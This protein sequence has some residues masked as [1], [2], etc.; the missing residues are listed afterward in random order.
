MSDTVHVEVRSETCMASGYCI[1]S[2]PAVFGADE[3]GWVLLLDADP[4]GH[5]AEVQQAAAMCP[6]AAID[7]FDADGRQL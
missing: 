1:R 4:R 6:V 2:A 3:N 5:T 7:V